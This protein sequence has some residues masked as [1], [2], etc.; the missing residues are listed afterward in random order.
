MSKIINGSASES[1][2]SSFIGGKPVAIAYAKNQDNPHA[3][4]YEFWSNIR[5]PET[6]ETL[7]AVKGYCNPNNFYECYYAEYRDDAGNFYHYLD[8]RYYHDPDFCGT[9]SIR[10]QQSEDAAELERK[11][12]SQKHKDFFEQSSDLEQTQSSDR[13][14]TF[15]EN[16]ES[17]NTNRSTEGNSISQDSSITKINGNGNFNGQS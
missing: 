5:H 16:K 10:Q 9:K 11:L 7:Q 3:Y 15:F 17:E 13:H 8:S 4:Y 14:Q 6:G 2:I 1:E 12:D